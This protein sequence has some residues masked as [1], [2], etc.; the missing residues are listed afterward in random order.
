MADLARDIDARLERIPEAVAETGADV[1]IFSEVWS[2]HDRKRMKERMHA[3]GY[4]HDFESAAIPARQYRPVAAQACAAGLLALGA[5]VAARR[6]PISR[7]AWLRRTVRGG[8]AAAAVV[9]VGVMGLEA[10]VV[11]SLGNGLMVFSKYP[12]SAGPDAQLVFS[13]VTRFDENYVAKGGLLLQVAVP[14]VGPIDLAV[15][16]LGAVSYDPTTKQYNPE[17]AKARLAQAQEFWEFVQARHS[18]N[19]P[20]LLATDLNAH[21]QRWNAGRRTT[22]WAP[23]YRLFTDPRQPLAMQDSYLTLHPESLRSPAWTFAPSTNP[24][25]GGGAFSEIPDEVIDY[26][27]C[28][29]GA[30]GIYLVPVESRIVFDQPYRGFYLSDHYGL[31][32]AFEVRRP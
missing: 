18:A 29:G 4:A 19:R 26:L 24:Y 32:S 8:T 11:A 1:V 12:L 23:E 21:Y 10:S 13:Q 25:A 7:R 17:H 27:M 6:T 30:G 20:L 28:G 9:A 2:P 22:E 5:E 3:Q 14:Q 15:A 16:H 31:F